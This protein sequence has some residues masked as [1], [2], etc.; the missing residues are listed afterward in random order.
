VDHTLYGSTYYG[1]PSGLDGGV[2]F[3][4]H[5]N[6]TH[7]KFLHVF[8]GKEGANPQ[9]P[10]VAGPGGVFYGIT[11][12]GGPEKDGNSGVLFA[13]MPDGTYLQLHDFTGT[14]D[15]GNPVS[16]VIDAAGTLYGSTYQPYNKY[17]SSVFSYVP[18]TATFTVLHTFG[19]KE[20][21][22]PQLGSIGP[23]GTLYGATALNGLNKAAGSLFELIPA[24]D[25]T[26]SLNTLYWFRYSKGIGGN[27]SGGPILTSY[28]ALIGTTGDDGGAG[29]IYRYKFNHM[30]SL[31]TFP[32]TSY[33]DLVPPTLDKNGIIYGAGS[34]G[35]TEP[36]TVEGQSLPAGFVYSF[37]DK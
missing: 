11:E 33:A 9:G 20:G 31:Y 14:T 28:G 34:Q 36:C 4:V 10:L 29:A 35:F 37:I 30:T 23:D 18:S 6:G 19:L 12:F 13:L 27:P 2:L 1:G 22:W 24:G 26:Y 8:H 21:L 16:L 7:Y 32:I 15:G 17:G 25:G 5:A 3:S